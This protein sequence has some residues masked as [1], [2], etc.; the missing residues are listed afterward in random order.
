MRY[1]LDSNI[2]I[3]V[4]KAKNAELIDRFTRTRVADLTTCSPVRAELMHGAEK[5]SDAIGRRERVK[6]ALDRVV[7]FPFDDACAERYGFIRHDLEQRRCVIGPM[8]LQ[9]AA[10]ALVHDLTVV[11]GNVNEFKRVH[12]LRV[13]DWSLPV[14]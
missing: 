3:E 11:T 9:I 13:E 7:S 2:W 1:L 4:L 6:S 5:Y 8:D 10:I 14:A 12:G